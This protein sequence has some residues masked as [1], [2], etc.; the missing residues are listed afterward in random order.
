MLAS[1]IVLKLLASCA[2]WDL[3]LRCLRPPPPWRIM[4]AETA[5]TESTFP[6]TREAYGH[7]PGFRLRFGTR[8][9]AKQL[10]QASA[11][12][13]PEFSGPLREEAT[14]LRVFVDCKV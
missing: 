7:R 5:E 3:S 12:L 10:N 13:R 11:H 2:G 4:Q 1:P 9:D 14:W 8:A 6:E